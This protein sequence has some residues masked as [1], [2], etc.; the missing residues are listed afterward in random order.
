MSSAHETKM[1]ALA[2]VCMTLR[3]MDHSD[4][5]SAVREARTFMT[6]AKINMKGDIAGAEGDLVKVRLIEPVEEERDVLLAYM[7]SA[8]IYF[9]EFDG[10]LMTPAQMR[11]FLVDHYETEIRVARSRYDNLVRR[12]RLVWAGRG[13]WEVD[14]IR[15]LNKDASKFDTRM[16]FDAPAVEALIAAESD[17]D[18]FSD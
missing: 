17:S 7:Q 5:A 9:G 15:A 4:A 14:A 8:S 3:Q 12:N 11:D 18:F 16:T 1:Q 10:V 2:Q 13:L 6:H